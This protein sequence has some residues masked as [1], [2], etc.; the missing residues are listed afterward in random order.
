MSRIH[1]K[2]SELPPV[3][4]QSGATRKSPPG[5]GAT[6]KRHWKLQPPPLKPPQ[7]G[8]LGLMAVALLLWYSLGDDSVE[9]PSLEKR[10]VEI[11]ITPHPASP[12]TEPSSPLKR[13]TDASPPPAD[14]PAEKQTTALPVPTPGKPLPPDTATPASPQ[15]RQDPA[16]AASKPDHPGFTKVLVP[17]KEGLAGSRTDQVPQGGHSQKPPAP[18]NLVSL[19]FE[20]N[21]PATG[22]LR[23]PDIPAFAM[24]PPD[25]LA[26]T[27]AARDKKS[28]PPEPQS[29]AREP[30]PKSAPAAATDSASPRPLSDYTF[31]Y[32]PDKVIPRLPDSPVVKDLPRI[33]PEPPVVKDLPRP[34][35]T[36]PAPLASGPAATPLS[37]PG[38]VPAGL[39]QVTQPVLAEVASSP[40]R[41]PPRIRPPAPTAPSPGAVATATPQDR[42][43]VPASALA[44][45]QSDPPPRHISSP[46]AAPPGLPL[47]QPGEYLVLLGSYKDM[48]ILEKA[49]VRLTRAGFP[50]RLAQTGRGA[51]AVIHLQMGPYASRDDAQ[52]VARMAQDRT[53]LQARDIRARHFLL[54]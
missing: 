23:E 34:Q 25:K 29:T 37:R 46:V 2:L 27:P 53:G 33:P 22:P 4:A 38:A 32:T 24:P 26:G 3:R 13:L 48:G 45:D 44:P 39:P 7:L 8:A 18:S 21:P 11:A 30:L 1:R 5:G 41:P 54:R 40:V 36:R 42:R 47:P 17:L 35:A 6:R 31:V 10:A 43:N 49:Q 15:P 28:P 16:V 12:S 9:S 20:R 14:A 51:Q 19:P 50:V 52:R